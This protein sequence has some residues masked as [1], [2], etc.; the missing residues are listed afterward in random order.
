LRTV[1]SAILG[2][3]TMLPLPYYRRLTGTFS[4]VDEQADYCEGSKYLYTR[5]AI[6]FVVHSF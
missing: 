2:K 6:A 5:N 1:A 3:E 4:T